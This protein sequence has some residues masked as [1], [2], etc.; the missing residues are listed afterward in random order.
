MIAS[1][2]N[3]AAV[4]CT[5]TFLGIPVWHKYVGT[6]CGDPQLSSLSDVWNVGLA[7]IEILL[8][9][10]GYIAA[11]FIIYGGI[12]MVISQGSPDKLTQARQTITYAIAGLVVV[13]IATAVVRTIAGGF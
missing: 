5:K 4:A 9:A 3:F 1:L 6:S 10:S 12:V 2:I 11:G 7:I 13:F 8:S